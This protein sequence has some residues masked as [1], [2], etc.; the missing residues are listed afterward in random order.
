MLFL[1]GK[2][3]KKQY[4]H[5]LNSPITATERTLSCILR[6]CQTRGGVKVPKV[7]QP[8]MGGKTFLPF[9]VNQ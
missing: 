8:Y 5:L 9:D 3:K 7:L 6:N 2:D 4:C 1:Q